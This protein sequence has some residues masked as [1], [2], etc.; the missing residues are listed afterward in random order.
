MAGYAALVAA[1]LVQALDGRAPL[2]LA[3]LLAVVFWISVAL[4]VTAVAMTLIGLA[5]VARQPS[6]QVAR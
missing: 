4:I 1:S 3:G 2:D 6:E 5:R